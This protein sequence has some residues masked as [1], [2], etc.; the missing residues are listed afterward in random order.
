ME[1]RLLIITVVAGG[2][3][4]SKQKEIRGG[5]IIKKGGIRGRARKD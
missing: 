4:D 3:A 1:V 2:H 5:M